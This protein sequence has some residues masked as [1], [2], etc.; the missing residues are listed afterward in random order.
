MSSKHADDWDEAAIRARAATETESAVEEAQP[1]RTEE[2]EVPR[3]KVNTIAIAF[4]DDEPIFALPVHNITMNAS[5]AAV[6]AA[7]LVVLKIR[8]RKFNQQHFHAGEIVVTRRLFR[9]GD[10]EYLLNG[11]LCRLR[12]IQ[13]LFMGT[14]LGPET[15][16]LIEQGRIGQI[17]SSRPTDRRAILE[18]AAGITKFKTKKRLAEAR[19]EDAKLNLARVN[20]IFEEVTRQMNS[21][22]RQASKAERFAKLRDEMRVELR[23]VLASKFAAIEQESA[24]LDTKLSELAA[25]M[26]QRTEAVQQLEAEHAEGTER[27][28]AIEAE[29]R[30]NRD[31]LSQLAMEI[32]RARARRRHNEERCAEI[33]VRSASAETELAQARHR[34]TCAGGGSGFE[35]AGA[36]ISGGGPGGCTTGTGVTR[37]RKPPQRLRRWRNWNISWKN[38]A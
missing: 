9:S 31:R 1:G 2:V 16:A 32:D 12:D 7:P 34:L 33:V 19:L 13:D 18:E 23:V 27:G 38:R 28:Y 35:P 17:F 6:A 20:D 22:K 21:L 10:S 14:G 8:R 36:G 26:Q 30:D 11:K 37:S 3:S 29:L 25:D 4:P 24:E 5:S 15:Y